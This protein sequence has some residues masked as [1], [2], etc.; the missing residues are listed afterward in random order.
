MKP[1]IGVY[2]TSDVAKLLRLAAR[3]SGATKSDIVNGAVARFL[4]PP[5][6]SDPNEAVLQRLDRLA[7]AVRRLHRDVE[8]MTETLAL[9]IR[10]FLTITPPVP[11]SERQ[12]AERRWRRA[13]TRSKQKLRRCRSEARHMEGCALIGTARRSKTEKASS[14]L[15]LAV[16]RASAP[17]RQ[18]RRRDL[19]KLRC[20]AADD[21]PPSI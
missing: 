9:H 6:E 2:L 20:D 12:E 15:W 5:P 19:E 7:K 11:R 13:Y 17:H 10:Q 21:R 14:P 16:G 3:R 1:K 4:D 18:C 8:I